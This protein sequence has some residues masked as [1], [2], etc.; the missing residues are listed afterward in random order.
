MSSVRRRVPCSRTAHL[1]TF[2]T[3]ATA[4]KFTSALL[5]FFRGA[6]KASMTSPEVAADLVMLGLASGKAQAVGE[7]WGAEKDTL[8][9]CAIE[10]TLTVNKLLDMDWRFGV[11]AS[12]KCVLVR[13]PCSFVCVRLCFVSRAHR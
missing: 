11:V 10:S 2:H 13:C 12:S 5:T 9:K 7:L 4:R 3:A 6:L 8:T 1:T